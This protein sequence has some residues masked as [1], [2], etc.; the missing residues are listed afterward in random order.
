[1]LIYLDS[2]SLVEIEKYAADSR[3]S[4]FTTNPT[5]IRQA[6]VTNYRSFAKAVLAAIG[7][8]E[9][10][11]EVLADSDDGMT[12]QALEIASWGPKVYVKIPIMY[13]DGSSTLPLVKKLTSQGVK[14]NVTAVM[15]TRQI[16]EVFD[17]IEGDHILSIFVGRIMDTGATG[18]Q[19]V[20][21][22]EQH[23]GASKVRILWAS[24]RE[25]YNVYQAQKCCDIVTVT[26]QILE[27]MKLHK[28]PLTEYSL[29]TV[30]QFHQDG[31]G[32]AF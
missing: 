8:K 32:I 29:E 26:P 18:P 19:T 25:V 3:I 17:A 2:G 6:A 24:V 9:V 12:R 11:F 13:T 22:A 1:V 23:R 31:K 14:V 10:S 27:K 16:R 5:L 28:K 30:K 7:D 21:Y 4:G 20:W 15:T